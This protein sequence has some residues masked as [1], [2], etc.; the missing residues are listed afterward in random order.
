MLRVITY[1]QGYKMLIGAKGIARGETGA[2]AGAMRARRSAHESGSGLALGVGKVL[3]ALGAAGDTARSLKPPRSP[4]LPNTK[5]QR[6]Q[7]Q[8]R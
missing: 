8:P 3:L 1:G 7:V 4:I 2:A 5:P 6:R